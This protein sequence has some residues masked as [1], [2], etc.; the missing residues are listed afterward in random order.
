MI[1]DVSMTVHESMTVYKNKKEKVPVFKTL[2]THQESTSHET[3]IEM[4]LHTGTHI[5]YPLHMIKEGKV[6]GEDIL[7]GLIGKAKVF[8]C[9]KDVIDEDF[10]NTCEIQKGDVV[11][12]KTRNS[13]VEHFDFDF[14]Y[15]AESA[16]IKLSEIGVIGVGLDALGIERA[17]DNH[18]TH[19]ILLSQDIFILEGLRLKNIDPKTYHMICLPLKIKGVEALPVRC[20]LED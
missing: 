11:L 14:V 4:S 7:E 17:Q 10:I 12:F 5:D 18:P 15:V 19:K 16:A 3:I 20:L 2:S 8:E 6:S 9:H 13:D 1:Y